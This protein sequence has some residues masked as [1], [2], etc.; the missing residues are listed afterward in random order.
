MI[1]RLAAYAAREAEN[2]NPEETRRQE[3]AAAR[4][5]AEKVK[6]QKA[7]AKVNGGVATYNGSTNSVQ[8]STSGGTDDGWGTPAS[9]SAT[10]EDVANSFSNAS[11]KEDGVPNVAATTAIA[12]GEKDSEKGKEKE[13]P[14]D[15]TV[16]KK[17]RGIPENVKLFEVF[18]HQIVEL[19]KVW[20][21]ST[22]PNYESNN[23]TFRPDQIYPFKT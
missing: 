21:H 19:I 12:D 3:E 1:D 10:A 11:L 9:T 7:R 20:T 23:C 6:Q 13:T 8:Q 17:F 5:L 2:E 14:E 18:W 16:V 15:T 4:R 22:S